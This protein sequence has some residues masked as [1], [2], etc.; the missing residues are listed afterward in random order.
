MLSNHDSHMLMLTCASHV[1]DKAFTLILNMNGHHVILTVLVGYGRVIF[2]LS[3]L[4]LREPSSLSWLAG[5]KPSQEHYSNVQMVDRTV[6]GSHVGLLYSV[7]FCK[8]F[9]WLEVCL[10]SS[11]LQYLYHPSINTTINSPISYLAKNHQ[12]IPLHH[13]ILR[14][15]HTN[16]YIPLRFG[17]TVKFKLINLFWS[18][19]KPIFI[20]DKWVK[21]TCDEHLDDNVSLQPWLNSC[22]NFQPNL[23]SLPTWWT[24]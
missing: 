6:F 3:S 8:V 14:T 22:F 2:S 18:K 4:A 23:Q 15:V 21:W 12:H 9:S 19:I 10:R 5:G 17:W 11:S 1:T 16:H 7:S 20:S 13:K 24:N